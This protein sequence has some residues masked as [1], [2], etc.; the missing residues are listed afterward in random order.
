MADEF[1]ID[2]HKLMFHPK[3]VADWLAA[4]PSTRST[5][6]SHPPVPVITGVR[7]VP[8]LHGVQ[9]AV[10]EGGGPEGTSH[11]NGQ[12]RAQERH[13][14]RRGRAVPA[15]GHRRDHRSHK[16]VRH[17]CGDHDQRR[18]A[19]EEAG[20][21]GPGQHGVDQG[22]PER[23]LRRDLLQGPPDQDGRFRTGLPEP[24]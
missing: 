24:L 20:G 17:R 22:E 16:T 6:R 11:G 18:A 13:V 21:T 1:R 23:R 7:S 12:A 4:D 3:R 19:D 2:S 15:Q 8:R 5:Q 14:R 9:A 10:P